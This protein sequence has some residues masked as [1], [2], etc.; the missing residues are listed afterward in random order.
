[1]EINL[2]LQPS[3]CRKMQT[4]LVVPH[5][6]PTKGCI[7][8]HQN[9]LHLIKLSSKTGDDADNQEVSKASSDQSVMDV[10]PNATSIVEIN[11][12]K[13]RHQYLNLPLLLNVD[14][15]NGMQENTTRSVRIGRAA[16]SGAVRRGR[17][18]SLGAR[19]RQKPTKCQE[20]GPLPP[21]DV[22]EIRPGPPL[23]PA[24]YQFH[25]MNNQGN[26]L[27]SKILIII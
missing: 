14:L 11:E 16:S 2:V 21:S 8:N 1:M 17:E 23:T 5:T 15:A 26:C 12:I 24:P 6:P 13:G 9:T 22:V 10:Q 25:H 7:M 4:H 19:I 20:S 27:R 3:Q 18:V